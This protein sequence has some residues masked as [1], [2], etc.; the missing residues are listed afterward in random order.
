MQR[1]CIGNCEGWHTT[2]KPLTGYTA[3]VA[4][5]LGPYGG[6]R[7]QEG[8]VRSRGRL[9]HLISTPKKRKTRRFG[10]LKYWVAAQKSSPSP[11]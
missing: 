1:I 10:D 7:R 6:V 9:V 3:V 11:Q 8:E 2:C 4:R 5:R